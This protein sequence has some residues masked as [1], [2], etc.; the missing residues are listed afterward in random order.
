MKIFSKKGK[1]PVDVL[2]GQQAYDF[3]LPDTQSGEIKLSDLRGQP[4]IL[5]FYPKDNTAVCSSQLALYNEVLDMF[6]E[7]D[8]ILLGI[9]IDDLDTHRVFADSLKLDFPLLSDAEPRGEVAQMYGVYDQKHEISKRAL[10]VI[11]KDGIIQ[12]SYISPP[13][14]NPGADGILN[15]LENLS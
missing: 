2:L 13:E 11:D 14:V 6:K 5:A 9:S 3:S 7:Y 8:A 10:F 1:Q 15:A 4:V 12:W